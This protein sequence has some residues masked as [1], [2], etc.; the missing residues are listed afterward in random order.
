LFLAGIRIVA[1]GGLPPSPPILH[2]QAPNVAMAQ[3]VHM[4]TQL[5]LL[6]TAAENPEQ[7]ILAQQYSACCTLNLQC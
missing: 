1:R 3:I 7:M 6:T 2:H 4:L 5:S